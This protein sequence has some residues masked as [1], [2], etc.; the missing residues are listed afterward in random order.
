MLPAGSS[1]ASVQ[2]SLASKVF[3]SEISIG[4]QF[5]RGKRGDS[6][7][8]SLPQ[9]GR[10][11]MSLTVISLNGT[12]MSEASV[13]VG[14]LDG[15]R[16]PTG[17][18]DLLPLAEEWGIGDDAAREAKVQS[19]SISE[20]RRLVAAVDSTDDETLYGWLSGPESYSSAPSEEYVAMTCL[21]MAADAARV[22]LAG[23]SS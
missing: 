5:P 14:S 8:N 19:S 3:L 6:R 15:S 1:T 13:S 20:L 17:L 21:T 18:R 9:L 4:Q 12:S 16:V 2:R 7:R 10:R 11:L 23:E 22:R